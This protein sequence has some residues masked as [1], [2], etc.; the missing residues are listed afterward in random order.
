MSEAAE[1]QTYARS[2]EAHVVFRTLNGVVAALVVVSALVQYNDPDPARWMIL[3]GAAGAVAV[4]AAVRGSVPLAASATLGI[5]AL[6]W[7]AAL[8]LG[9]PSPDIYMS[10]FAA[11]EMKSVAVEEA[12]EASGLFIIGAWMAVL[13]V[14]TRGGCRWT[15]RVWRS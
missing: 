10:M 11:W 9:V 12:R 5:I 8:A 7:G 1:S 3:Y 15:V 2:A 6:A 13:A 4:T 14:H